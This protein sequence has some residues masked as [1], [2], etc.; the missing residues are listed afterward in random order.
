ML[1]E[2]GMSEP[3]LLMQMFEYT[4][5]I[6]EQRKKEV[7]L[8]GIR[9]LA[10]MQTR[11]IDLASTLRESAETVLIVQ[12]KR[13]APEMQKP[14]ETYDPGM[15]AK[16]FVANGARAICVATN[17]KFYLG[18][19]MD[20]ILVKQSVLVPVIRQDLIY[21]EYQIVEARAAGAD[22]VVLIAAMLP[23][24][25]LRE[26]ISITQR[27]RMTEVVQVQDR[28]ELLMALQFEPRVI[29]ISNRDMRNL[30]VHL[31]NTLHLRNLIPPHIRV[32]SMGGLWT[33]EDVARVRTA[34]L[35]AI[36]VGQVLLM[37]EDTSRAIQE[38]FNVL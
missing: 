30:S 9:A 14:L 19:V 2:I 10:S 36:L 5:Q 12:L 34:N 38:L 17:P 8:K 32:I 11:P 24:E 22:G 25:K 15:M 7:P 31:E 13:R 26:L 16:N 4:R 21:D 18:D 35:D 29:A 33:A 1:R 37:A 23:P 28:E 6:V 20:L 3:N 27:N